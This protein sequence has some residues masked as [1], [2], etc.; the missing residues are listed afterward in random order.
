MIIIIHGKYKYTFVYIWSNLKGFDSSKS[1]MCVYFDTEGVPHNAS[2][3][4]CLID[5]YKLKRDHMG[6][7]TCSSVDRPARAL[8]S[9]I[10]I[11]LEQ[12]VE[13][14]GRY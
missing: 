6:A 4:T 1:E 5:F 8:S 14:I 7:N 10:E 9:T 12:L 13:K 11:S 2:T 3:E